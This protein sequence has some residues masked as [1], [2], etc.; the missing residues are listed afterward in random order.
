M[1]TCVQHASARFG[2]VG[3]VDCQSCRRCAGRSWAVRV[4]VGDGRSR[5]WTALMPPSGGWRLPWSATATHQA[6]NGRQACITSA[7]GWTMGIPG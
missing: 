5:R 3:R 2:R 4:G 6:G 1:S 7:S